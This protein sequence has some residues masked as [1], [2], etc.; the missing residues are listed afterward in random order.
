[1][2]DSREKKK[3]TLRLFSDDLDILRTAYPGIG[4]NQVVRSLVAKHVRRLRAAAVEATPTL[5]DKLTL[6]DLN[7]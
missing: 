6:E 7:V 5:P 3:I 1:M 2:N 4:Y